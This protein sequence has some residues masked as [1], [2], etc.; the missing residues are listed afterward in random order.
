MPSL[1]N[2]HIVG[3][4][5]TIILFLRARLIATTTHIL[6]TL[7]EA[8]G[9]FSISFNYV[10]C[11]TV[12][13]AGWRI[14]RDIRMY[15]DGIRVYRLKT[16]ERVTSYL[17]AVYFPHEI[18]VWLTAAG[19]V[20]APA[21]ITSHGGAHATQYDGRDYLWYVSQNIRMTKHKLPHSKI[22]K[23]RVKNIID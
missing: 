17:I 6:R 2:T 13:C 22:I 7:R 3:R 15:T 1:D 19:V 20:C 9:S 14:F 12:E 4:L 23:I 18:T 5:T 21:P 8:R 10:L 16:N 11:D